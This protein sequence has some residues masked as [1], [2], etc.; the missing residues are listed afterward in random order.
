MHSF[1]DILLFP[2]VHRWAVDVEGAS[3]TLYEGE[4][5]QLQF[6]FGPRYPFDSPQVRILLPL[7]IRYKRFDALLISFLCTLMSF[8]GRSNHSFTN[9]CNIL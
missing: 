6:K 9:T 3:G 1:D 2:C 8:V 7:N 4:K 5:F